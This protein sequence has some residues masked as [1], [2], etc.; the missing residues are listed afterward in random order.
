MAD[1]TKILLVEDDFNLGLVI[2]DFLSLE[3]YHVHLCR[4]GKEGL[5]KFNKNQYDLCLLDVMLPEKDGFSIAEDIRKVNRSV[6]I[7]FLTAKSLPEDKVKGFKAGG[8][9]YITKP[10]NNEEFL[11]R[12]KAILKRTAGTVVEEDENKGKYELGNYKFDSVNLRLYIKGEEKKL[13]KRE[14]AILKLLTEH[15]NKVIERS[16]VLNLIWGDDNYFNGRSLDV[17]ITKLRKYLA[18]DDSIQINNL[19]GVGFKLE[20]KE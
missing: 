10:F 16:L 6:P 11:L 3:G 17:F 12:I 9:D 2:Q 18:D 20:V 1:K 19:H 4:D 7:I 5:Q 14:S 15:K 8:D 13:T